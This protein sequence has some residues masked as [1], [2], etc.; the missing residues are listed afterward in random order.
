[1]YTITQGPNC[2]AFTAF[3]LGKFDFEYAFEYVHVT[4][5]LFSV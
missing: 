5:F 2:E 4:N 1:M 3:A